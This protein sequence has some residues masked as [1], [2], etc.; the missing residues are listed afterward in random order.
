MDESQSQLMNGIAASVYSNESFVQ[1]K[2]IEVEIV[3]NGTDFIFKHFRLLSE[4]IHQ[5]QKLSISKVNILILEITSFD[6]FEKLESLKLD[7]VSLLLIHAE[8][9][10]SI[11]NHL[12]QLEINN[13]DVSFLNLYNA[14][15]R[16]LFQQLKNLTFSNCR[17]PTV[18]DATFFGL[19]SVTHIYF[20]NCQIEVIKRG[21]FDAIQQTV[22][23]IDLSKNYLTSIDGMFTDWY[24]FTMKHVQIVLHNNPIDCYE[25]DYFME[26]IATHPHIF[27]QDICKQYTPKL[28]YDEEKPAVTCDDGHLAIAEDYGSN[29]EDRLA[30]H[31]T[32]DLNGTVHIDTNRRSDHVLLWKN[33][34]YSELGNIAESGCLHSSDSSF[35]LHNLSQHT[36]YTFCTMHK[37][38][39]AVSPYNCF[40]YRHMLTVYG[41]ELWISLDYQ[42]LTIGML[43]LVYLGCIAIGFLI[44]YCLFKR[45]PTLLRGGK[46]VVVVRNSTD[47]MPASVP[48]K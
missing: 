12:K 42:T 3:C 5:I 48:S 1:Y 11:S 4:F 17:M 13:V 2:S 6:G 40:P 46:G 34:M 22:L 30:Y 32:T 18:N 8:A 27:S 41:N 43:V 19:I 24:P 45:Y 37:N 9:L 26:F 14:T 10:Q 33:N 31:I 20:I 16:N 25:M 35:T 23:Y 44:A 21:A 38:K 29:E 47:F 7:T 15:G 36:T 28:S 39:S